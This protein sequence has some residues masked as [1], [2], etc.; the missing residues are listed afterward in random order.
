M[1]HVAGSTC[2]FQ[3]MW[4]VAHLFFLFITGIFCVVVLYIMEDDLC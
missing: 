2:L 4:Q 1:P 3:L